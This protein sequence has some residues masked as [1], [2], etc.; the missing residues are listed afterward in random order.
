[1]S[2]FSNMRISKD[3]RLL[4]DEW[5]YNE[6]KR[7]GRSEKGVDVTDTALF[8]LHDGCTLDDG[9]IFRDILLLIENMDIYSSLSPLL[10]QGPWLKDM[11]DEGLTGESDDGSSV[12]TIV[13]GWCPSVQDD[14]Y[15]EDKSLFDVYTNVYGK[16]NEEEFKTY[17]L[18]F[19]P[20]YKFADCAV[21]LDRDFVIQDER[22]E[23][24]KGRREYLDSLSEE[25][26][27]KEQY[28]P[29]LLTTR[30]DFTLLD[31]IHGLFWKLSFHGGPK[32]RDAR[33]AELS[34]TIRKIESGEEKC[35]P[36]EDIKK[37]IKGEIE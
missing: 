36:W 15:N 7:K 26:Y 32:D 16:L 5:I 2:R 35:T 17:A 25:E 22:K 29:T 24:L 31:I 4:A 37:R 8:R 12:D 27:Q 30:Q 14:F 3:G 11:V 1:M 13:I 6:E 34:E 10:T 33:L 23:S 28:Y 9:V 20:I 19:T 18:D 21:I